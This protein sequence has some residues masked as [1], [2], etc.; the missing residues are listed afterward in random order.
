MKFD[1]NLLLV[2]DALIK[3]RNVTR[4]GERLGLSQPAVSAALGRLRVFFQDPL[5][6]RT[7]QGMLPTQRAQELIEPLGRALH[8]IEETVQLQTEFDPSE[9]QRKFSILMMDIGE[10]DFLP[11]LLRHLRKIGSSVCLETTQP[12]TAKDYDPM[13]AFEAGSIDLALGYWPQF[14]KRRGF[15]R[16]CLFTDSFVCV[17]R[18]DHP[19][20][21]KAITLEQVADASHVVVTT[22]GN[23]DGVIER[24]LVQQNL[25]RKVVVKVPHFLAVPAIVTNSDLV[26]T[27][28]KGFANVLARIHPLRLLPPPFKLS[29]FEVS[30]YWHCR[31]NHDPGLKWIIGTIGALF[32]DAPSSTKD[33]GT[34]G[35]SRRGRRPA[36]GKRLSHVKT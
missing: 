3:E 21:G 27:I 25:T 31:F 12:A 11:R 19:K 7:S 35:K 5:F 30:V 20:I 28:P 23:T 16:Q 34:S 8:I 6:A 4:A 13:L 17:V 36:T 22:H 10:M 33:H 26:A 1:L 2:F 14:N 18:K 15:E 29:P 32:S 9:S 24:A